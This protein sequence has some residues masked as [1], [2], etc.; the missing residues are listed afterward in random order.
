M[1]NSGRWTI[2][3]DAENRALSFVSLPSAPLAS[4]KKVDCA[5]YFQ[6]R[7]VQ[8]IAST[9][10]GSA[11]IPVYTNKFVYDGWNLIAM[12]RVRP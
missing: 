5:Y 1:T 10:N 12:N 11:W 6:G 2:T 7:R 4:Q 3:W 9:N 8:K